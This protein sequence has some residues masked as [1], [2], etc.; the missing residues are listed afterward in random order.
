MKAGES[1]SPVNVTPRSLDLSFVHRIFWHTSLVSRALWQSLE[2]IMEGLW[3]GRVPD[4]VSQEEPPDKL[5]VKGAHDRDQ[6]VFL[7]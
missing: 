6:Q 7:F 3:C 4:G 1:A 5:T 2:I